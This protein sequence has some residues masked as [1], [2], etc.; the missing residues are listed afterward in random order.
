[1]FG[2][3][4]QTTE[5]NVAAKF[6]GLSSEVKTIKLGFY[7]IRNQIEKR[8]FLPWIGRLGRIKKVKFEI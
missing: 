8:K 7:T 6:S 3:N 5:P 2:L 4:M 1:M